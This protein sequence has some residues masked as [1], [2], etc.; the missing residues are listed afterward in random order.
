MCRNHD[1]GIFVMFWALIS[2]VRAWLSQALT[3]MKMP[4]QACL[5]QQ[6][7][8]YRSRRFK[9]HAYVFCNF[10][11]SCNSFCKAFVLQAHMLFLNRCRWRRFPRGL[12]SVGRIGRGVLTS[13]HGVVTILQVYSPVC[14]PAV[15]FQTHCAN[16]AMAPE[17]PMEAASVARSSAAWTRSSW[18]S[19][20]TSIMPSKSLRSLQHHRMYSLWVF[21]KC[22]AS[23]IFSYNKI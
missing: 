11:S 9:H 14:P 19:S 12:P 3:H 6:T 17:S 15:S 2:S 8:G 16:S 10:P 1:L 5:V 13:V 21:R 18:F 7:T 20:S 22:M 23:K 4:L